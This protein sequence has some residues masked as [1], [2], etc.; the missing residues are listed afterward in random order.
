LA[1]PT[2]VEVAKRDGVSISTVSRCLNHPE[3]VGK[4]TLLR[5]RKVIDD[6]NFSPNALAQSLRRGKTSIILVVVHEIGSGLLS[7]VV[8]GNRSV[9]DGR[10]AV[11]LTESHPDAARPASFIDML[12]AKQVEGVILLCSVPPF[13]RKIIEI[14]KSRNLPIVIGLEPLGDELLKLPG[15]HIDNFA[16]ATEATNYLIGLGHRAI[17]F[18]SGP[19]QSYVTLDRER[20]FI[21]AMARAG[22]DSSHVHSADLSVNG[23]INAARRLIDAIDNPDDPGRRTEICRTGWS[24]ALRRRPRRSD[25]EMHAALFAACLTLAAG[26]PPAAVA[27]PIFTQDFE[28]STLGLVTPARFAVDW[29]IA[30]PASSGVDQGRLA[31][32]SD[33][34]QPGNHVLRVRYEAGAIGGASAM[35]FVLP[36]APGHSAVWLSYRV[37]FA[38]DFDWVQG[39]KLPGL[40]G[41]D[42][43]TGCI[44]DGHFKGFTTRLMWRSGGRAVNYLYFPGKRERCGDDVD[45]GKDFERGRWHLITQKVVLNDPGVVNGQLLQYVDGRLHA[46]L[47]GRIWRREAATGVEGVRI[48]TFFGGGTLDWAPRVAQFA[49]FD[50]FKIWTGEPSDA[51]EPP[52]RGK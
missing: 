19:R 10:Y 39:G 24:F 41:G 22:R 17:A 20:G 51:F 28:R 29:G 2:I 47:D 33:P 11:I 14:N 26:S 48:E 30:A 43:P 8:E 21:D 31:I 52:P 13:S 3:K 4:K 34:Q 38:P 25:P 1:N 15:V 36:I 50:D 23:G 37:R 12:V 27:Q 5:V 18:V 35:N 45:L 9:L 16:A 49:W 32:V 6:I 7:E 40:G 46:R 44:A 42:F